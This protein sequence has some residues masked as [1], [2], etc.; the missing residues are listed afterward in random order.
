MK[1]KYLGIDCLLKYFT[2]W[3]GFFFKLKFAINLS[4]AGGAFT[5]IID[6]FFNFV[7]VY[8]SSPLEVKLC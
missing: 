7:E 1:L 2:K 4:L 5:Y 6:A 3:S 8:N